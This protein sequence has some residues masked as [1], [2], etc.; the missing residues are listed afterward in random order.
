MNNQ[1]ETNQQCGQCNDNIHRKE[2]VTARDKRVKQAMW[3]DNKFWLG[4]TLKFKI[5]DVPNF[6]FYILVLRHHKKLSI[7]S[8]EI[9]PGQ[10]R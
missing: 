3:A 9:G 6:S 2:S 5:L 1:T 4:I 7:R 10:I 8:K